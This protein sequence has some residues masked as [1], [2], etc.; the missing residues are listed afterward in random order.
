MEVP[1]TTYNHLYGDVVVFR[2]KLTAV[3]GKSFTD[4]EVFDQIWKDQTIPPIKRLIF[5]FTSLAIENDLFV[6]G[7]F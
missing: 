6:F 2:E 7:K 1:R 4:V 3:G 5:D